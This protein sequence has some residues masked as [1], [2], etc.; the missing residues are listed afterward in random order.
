MRAVDII[1]RKRD[2]AELTTDE[3]QTFIAGYTKGDITDYQAS[4]WLMAIYFK[5]MT[6]R[7][8][9]DL[10]MAMANS[11]ERLDLS[12]ILS[13]NVD[14]HSSGGVGD[15]TTM[16]V[17]PLV[18]ACGV[19]V[20]KMSGRGLG[21]TGGTID[22]LE[23]IPNF[24]CDLSID[25]FRSQLKRHGLALTGQTHNL[26]PAD[27]KLYAL[28]D[29][30][31]TVPS[32]PLIASSIMSKKIA[33][34]AQAVV[35]DVK[36][37]LGAFMTSVEEARRLAQLMVAIG[38]GTNLRIVAMISDMN[39]PLG[40]AVG[41]ALEMV[42][43]I[44]CLNN[45][46]VAEDLREHCVAVAAYMLWVARGDKTAS[47]EAL[48]KEVTAKI[49]NGAGLEKLITLVKAQ[50]GDE[51]A[52]R[53]PSLLPKAAHIK[54]VSTSRNGYIKQISAMQVGVAAMNLGAGR[55]RKEDKIDHAVGIIVH[56]KVG[57]TVMI[58]EP[59]FTIHANS[60][61]AMN[62]AQKMLENTVVYSDQPTLPLPTIYDVI[63]N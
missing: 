51:Q 27:G 42:E 35:L 23:A 22:K 60:P 24:R 16:I 53:N 10:T 46:P 37:G 4:A 39:Q 29:V 28:R 47:I 13:I 2:G 59:I 18:A 44:D 55:A 57:D 49:R 8:T 36:V 58:G 14:K 48:M 63:T 52:I 12:D 38:T 34:G 20:A 17:L 11:G 45:R 56:K 9:V 6:E 61:E 62:E 50:G 43:V 41:N 25:E 31:A 7:E 15:K 19:P 26:A 54:T 30:T 40:A 21:F 33:A 5:G 1:E 32:L 3:I